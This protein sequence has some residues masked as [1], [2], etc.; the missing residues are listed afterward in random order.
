MRIRKILIAL[1]TFVVIFGMIF[2]SVL[3]VSGVTIVSASELPLKPNHTLSGS[4]ATF[5]D[6]SYNSKDYIITSGNSLD[7]DKLIPG[8]VLKKGDAYVDLSETSILSDAAIDSYADFS[9]SLI[10]NTYNIGVESDAT[11]SVV[12]SE[13]TSAYSDTRLDGSV[14]FNCTSASTVTWKSDMGFD[15]NQDG[16]YD[17]TGDKTY[18][19]SIGKT[20]QVLYWNA[21]I[22]WNATD[23]DNSMKITWSF[24]TS[25]AN[26]YDFEIIYMDGNG[27][28]AWS[29]I[30]SSGENTITV[31]LYDTDAQ[32]IAEMASMDELLETDLGDNPVISGL[33]YLEVQLSANTGAADTFIL[34]TA[35]VN[36]FNVFT[37]YPAATDNSDNDKDFDINGDSGGLWT[38]IGDDNDFLC[39]GIVEDTTEIY[40][41]TVALYTDIET[42]PYS[43]PQDAKKI[44]FGGTFYYLPSFTI[45]SS[46]VSGTSY[47]L[48]TETWNYDTTS[49]N[50]LQTA[51]NVLTWT[52]TYYNMTLDE[53]VLVSAYTEFDDD[54]DSFSFESVDK[55]EELRGD[56]ASVIADG[57]KVNYDGSNPD[58]STGN[59]YDFTISYLTDK[60]YT[61]SGT[62][63]ISATT[64]QTDVMLLLVLGV[65]VAGSA[66]VA[67][68]VLKKKKK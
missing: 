25:G 40:D 11:A 10:N 4:T 18:R 58:T 47:Y 28:S 23:S 33:D 22:D 63:G 27:D 26:N 37:D 7:I 49:L 36:N 62:G 45:S 5:V 21:M 8:L 67:Y 32:Y 66:T 43:M 50:S 64:G 44:T 65:V 9:L 54:L 38:G 13:L 39:T 12:E 31:T 60:S 55:V 17:D 56:W 14:K 6:S 3:A 35:R 24:K 59:S 34:A 51:T 1:F 57:Q 2:G 46:L 15:Y 19:P 29:N 52:D 20:G 42:S 53:D 41:Y 30:D 48:T 16:D 61:G 68:I